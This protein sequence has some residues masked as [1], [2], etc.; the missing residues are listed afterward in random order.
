MI[1]ENINGIDKERKGDLTIENFGVLT[2]LLLSLY[3]L[4]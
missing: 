1:Q 3:C 4:D 2:I